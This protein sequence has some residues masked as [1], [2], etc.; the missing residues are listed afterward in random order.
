MAPA[1]GTSIGSALE[2]LILEGIT[3][4]G[5]SEGGGARLALLRTTHCEK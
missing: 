4:A 1:V 5:A 2:S 3:I